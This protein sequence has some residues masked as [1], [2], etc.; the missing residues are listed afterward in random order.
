MALLS[1]LKE[2]H[3]LI[4]N[5][6]LDYQERQSKTRMDNFPAEISHNHNQTTEGGAFWGSVL[7][8]DG[9]INH[10]KFYAKYPKELYPEGR[11]TDSLGADPVVV[12]EK[13][14]QK[15]EQIIE[16]NPNVIS[17]GDYVRGSDDNSEEKNWTNKILFFRGQTKVGLYITEDVEGNIRTFR[18][19]EK[20]IVGKDQLKAIE[21]MEKYIPEAN[22]SHSASEVFKVK[23]GTLVEMLKEAHN[24]K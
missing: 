24:S 20:V 6:I 4:Y 8:A 19:I 16:D 11:V 2:T 12:P 1:E 10:D 7:P 23:S 22:K 13:T 18:H 17:D 14:D 15:A 9:T 21:I 3:P 5:R